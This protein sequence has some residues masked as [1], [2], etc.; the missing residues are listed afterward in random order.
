MASELNIFQKN[1]KLIGKKNYTKSISRIQANDS[2]R[3]GYFCIWING[4]ML[5]DKSLLGYTNL[6]FRDQYEK[7]DKII[8]E[9]FQ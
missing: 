4:F 3:C 1:W 6:F 9:Y 2:I 8:F 5:K 7:N